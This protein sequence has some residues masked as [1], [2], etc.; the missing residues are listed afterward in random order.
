MAAVVDYAFYRKW[1]LAPL[2]IVWYNVFGHHGGGP[3][4]FGTEPW[5]FYLLNG[6]LQFNLA[7]PAALLS[8]FILV[9]ARTL[10]HY[11]FMTPG[12]IV[13]VAI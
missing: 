5:W 3:N 10:L 12:C 2:H 13:E 11:S 4:V 8:L 1:W 9:I 6:L 7:F